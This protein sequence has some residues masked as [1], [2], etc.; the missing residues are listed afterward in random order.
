VLS[1]GDHHR[2]RF[3]VQS[4]LLHSTLVALVTLTVL[5]CGTTRHIWKSEPEQQ[6]FSNDYVDVELSP[7]C[8]QKGCQAF[9]LSVSN[10]TDHV[11]EIDW[12]KTT[13]I[14]NGVRAAG[15]LVPGKKP[16]SSEK[17]K[18][19][20]LIQ[21]HFA[22]SGTIWPSALAYATREPME[23]RKHGI[24]GPG[25]NGINLRLKVNGKEMT[26][27]LTVMLSVRELQK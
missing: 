5:A 15:F 1:L 13:Y 8:D 26:E 6:R 10:K 22:R 12:E 27:R 25:E 23:H 21:P 14:T 17:P 2:W 19:P 18:S 20:E 16:E 3:I 24:M 11:I 4:R 7:V 9:Q